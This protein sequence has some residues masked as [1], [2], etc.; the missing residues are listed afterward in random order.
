MSTDA[1]TIQR[2]EAELVAERLIVESLRAELEV[3]RD[4]RTSYRGSAYLACLDGVDVAVHASP[5]A[6]R[7]AVWLLR[8]QRAD[9]A[10]EILG[11]RAEL[12][13]QDDDD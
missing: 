7:A 2:L 13:R 5:D 10:G 3:C 4:E 8:E 12:E 11:L 6:M 1:E 9:R